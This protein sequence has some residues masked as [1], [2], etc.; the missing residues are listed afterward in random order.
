MDVWDQELVNCLGIDTRPE[1]L[2]DRHV[3]NE[4]SPISLRNPVPA[5]R[6]L[7]S[8]LLYPN[9][10]LYLLSKLQLPTTCL[11]TTF[12]VFS[13]SHSLAPAFSLHGTYR[14]AASVSPFYRM[15]TDYTGKMRSYVWQAE[16]GHIVCW[17]LLQ[18]IPKELNTG[19][20]RTAKA[21]A[22][23]TCDDMYTPGTLY[24]LVY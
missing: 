16:S 15:H 2:Q 9:S 23:S 8:T 7:K 21:T 20:T 6:S 12:S 1:Q 17:V 14:L 18:G 4:T 11:D 3:V 24:G 10:N 22:K 13:F 19:P 5:M